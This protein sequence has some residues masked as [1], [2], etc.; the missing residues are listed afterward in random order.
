LYQQIIHNFRP[1]RPPIYFISPGL[2]DLLIQADVPIDLS[3]LTALSNSS[4]TI[5]TALWLCSPQDKCGNF[6]ATNGVSHR[7]CLS[8]SLGSTSE[9]GARIHPATL[10]VGAQGF[11]RFS[12]NVGTRRHTVPAWMHQREKAEDGGTERPSK[13]FGELSK[14]T[15]EAKG[16][17]VGDGSVQA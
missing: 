17:G 5:G 15:C 4:P 1:R 13:V 16:S 3:L 10:R 6:E 14:A 9:S 8:T 7:N 2:C 11:G 12:S